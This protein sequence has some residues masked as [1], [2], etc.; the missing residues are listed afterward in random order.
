MPLL[1]LDNTCGKR[2]ESNGLLLTRRM[3]YCQRLLR[4]AGGFRG[5]RE[6]ALSSLP[7]PQSYSADLRQGFCALAVHRQRVACLAPCI[8]QRPRSYLRLLLPI[9]SKIAGTR[10]WRLMIHGSSDSC[11]VLY[12][13]LCDLCAFAP[14]VALPIGKV[15]GLVGGWLANGREG[16]G[17]RG[18]GEW[19]GCIAKK[20]KKK[21]LGVGAKLQ[22]NT[23]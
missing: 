9:I 18:K 12:F 11:L 17:G 7:C 22:R 2:D 8:S 20:Q 10:R 1:L 23:V 3:L 4:G 21:K 15:E 14:A 13:S 16:R 6:M 5:G 19:H